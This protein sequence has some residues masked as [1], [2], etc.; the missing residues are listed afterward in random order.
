MTLIYQKNDANLNFLYRS[1]NMDNQ[2]AVKSF[3][4]IFIL[5]SLRIF[6]IIAYIKTKKE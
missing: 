5:T 6:L 3:L 2:K 4:V 1:A